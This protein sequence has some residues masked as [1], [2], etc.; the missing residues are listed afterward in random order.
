MHFIWHQISF[1]KRQIYVKWS[2]LPLNTFFGVMFTNLYLLSILALITFVVLF[3]IVV[4]SLSHVQLF[5]TQW[6]A[7]WQASL[8]VTIFRSLLK[9]LSIELV[10]LSNHLILCCPLL[11][12]PS[13]F[14]SIRIFSI[15]SSLHQLAKV[16]EL[17][18]QQQS[19]QWLV[20]ADF[21]KEKIRHVG[22]SQ[23]WR[24]GD[25]LP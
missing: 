17:Q 12:L 20:R 4:Q 13:I 22:D 15:R 18:L 11:L 6:T 21:L 2:T 19:F 10:I 3:F 7:A 23:T 8:Y 25:L 14:P 16:L 24:S 1:N 5:V 9:F